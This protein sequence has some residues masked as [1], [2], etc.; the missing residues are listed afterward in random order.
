ME[1][2]SGSNPEV[3][4][5]VAELRTL[6]DKMAERARVMIAREMVL[7]GPGIA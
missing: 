6:L 2:R 5:I 3:E 1:R 4:S 7:A